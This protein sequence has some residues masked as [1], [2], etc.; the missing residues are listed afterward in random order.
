MEY[1]KNNKRP[2]MSTNRWL[3]VLLILTI[4]LVNIAL[5]I[6]WAFIQKIS[7]TRRNFARATILWGIMI[8]L[9][10]VLVLIIFQ[11]NF[12]HIFSVLK[13]LKSVQAV[14]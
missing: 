14:E 7:H 4:P 2:S 9:I 1:T 6:Y 5:I 12:E 3:V 10:I 11:P 13:E 8:A